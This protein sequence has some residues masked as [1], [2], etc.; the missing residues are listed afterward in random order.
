MPFTP[1]YKFTLCFF[2][3]YECV[4]F[5]FFAEPFGIMLQT[6]GFFRKRVSPKKKDFLLCYHN[7]MIS[8]TT[9]I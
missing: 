3:P 2:P 9:V 4:L 8:F 1:I 5:V 6:T 7:M